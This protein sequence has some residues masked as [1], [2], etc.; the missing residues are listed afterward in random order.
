MASPVLFP[1]KSVLEVADCD[2]DFDGPPEGLDWSLCVLVKQGDDCATVRMVSDNATVHDIPLCF[3]RLPLD[4]ARKRNKPSSYNEALPEET[5]ISRA[6][7][8]PA[9]SPVQTLQSEPKSTPKRQRFQQLFGP[10][11]QP[12]RRAPQACGFGSEQGTSEGFHDAEGNFYRIGDTVWVIV[13]EAAD[14]PVKCRVGK[15]RNG[16]IYY[17]PALVA[18]ISVSSESGSSRVNQTIHLMAY[19]NDIMIEAYSIDPTGLRGPKVADAWYLL[20]AWSFVV[21]AASISG[22]AIARRPGGDTAHPESFILAGV[23]NTDDDLVA[24]RCCPL[25]AGMSQRELFETSIPEDFARQI[26]QPLVPSYSALDAHQIYP[27]VARDVLGVHPV[28]G[29]LHVGAEQDRG[30][31]AY[32]ALIDG[33]M[34]IVTVRHR[35][36]SPPPALHTKRS[37]RHSYCRWW[38]ATRPTACSSASCVA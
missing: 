24:E 26:R 17:C 13:E 27:P 28:L 19:V 9:A 14:V 21:T 34:C 2:H 31:V 4:T 20:P 3:L 15:A 25:Q 30:A 6:P 32:L 18:D 29:I 7:P 33:I 35:P 23:L 16:A 12:T 38:V 36:P 1:A 11:E 8:S 22:F 10:T 37:M 5:P